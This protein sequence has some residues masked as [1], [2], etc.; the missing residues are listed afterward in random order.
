VTVIVASKLSVWTA[1]EYDIIDALSAAV[2]RLIDAYAAIMARFAVFVT[3]TSHEG[4]VPAFRI[5][6]IAYSGCA[7]T[8]GGT[9][10]FR[11]RDAPASDTLSVFGR[12]ATRSRFGR[13]RLRSAR[14]EAQAH[15]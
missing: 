15:D 7:S 3:I 5:E 12:L 4:S 9:T 10:D 11:A 2:P 1:A 6:A 8:F 13:G 14:A